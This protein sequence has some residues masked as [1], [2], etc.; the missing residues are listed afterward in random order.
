[1]NKYTLNWEKIQ[2]KDNWILFLV[3]YYTIKM[4]IVRNYLSPNSTAQKICWHNYEYIA[5]TND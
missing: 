3:E 2:P 4:D 1:M 5:I